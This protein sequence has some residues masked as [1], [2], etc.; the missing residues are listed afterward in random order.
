MRSMTLRPHFT[1]R[2][3]LSVT[4]LAALAA[5][6]VSQEK[7][8][9]HRLF[10][11][12]DDALTA[13]GQVTFAVVGNLRAPLPLLD[14]GEGLVWH[15]GVTEAIQ[16]E[17]QRR[18]DAKSLKFVVLTGDEVRYS[19]DKEWKAWDTEW[20]DVFD[21]ETLPTREGYRLPVIPVV[22]DHEYLGDR[23][24][25]GVEG[26]FPGVGVDIG[27]NRVASWYHFDM[28]VGDSIWRFVILDSNK[29]K[30]GSRWNEQLYWIPRAAEG[31]YD[32]VV[33]FM[34]H[35]VVSLAPT[36]GRNEDG[37]PLEL[38]EALEENLK[39][40][41]LRAVFSGDAHTSEVIL[42]DGRLGSAHISAGGGGGGAEALERWGNGR[43]VNMGD[44]QLEPIF[45]VKL[46][47]AFDAQ[48]QAKAFPEAVIDKAKAR[49]SWEGFTATYDPTYFPLYGFWTVTI[50]GAD[51]YAE[52]V[53]W[54]PDG[55][56][57]EIYRVD[58]VDGDGWIAG[59][60]G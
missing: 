39:L 12:E 51:L 31:R 7:I 18:A 30:L 19:A 1:L 45:D 26:A 47:M 22:G 8:P 6:A 5:C 40:L 41:R 38:I 50:T 29:Q 16:A 20:R 57:E 25:K 4:G 35:P 56:F 33:T 54:Q 52:F 44:I 46:Q 9:D 58:Y 37:A 43:D 3:I 48:A 11:D 10:A 49:G 15:D 21:G 17:L 2:L 53:A 23:K 28:R 34:H 14:K 59:K 24:L 42:P 60:S 36:A 32:H 55:S 13:Q 27:F